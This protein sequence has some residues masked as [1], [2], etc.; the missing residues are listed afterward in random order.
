MM[1]KLT[2]LC[3]LAAPLAGCGSGPPHSDYYIVAFLP[4]TPAPSEPGLEA[5]DNAVQEAVHAPPRLIAIDGAA[6]AGETEPGLVKQRT[7]AVFA[8]FAKAGVDTTHVRFDIH[9]MAEKDYAE[10]KDSLI[11]QL[12]YGTPPRP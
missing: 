3:A 5:L 7:D 8:A 4:G 6:P 10:R 9:P 1:K 11:V 12:A 2:L